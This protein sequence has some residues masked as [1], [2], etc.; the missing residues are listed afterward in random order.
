MMNVDK[1]G[2]F[3]KT[4]EAI[5]KSMNKQIDGK[6][7]IAICVYVL[8]MVGIRILAFLYPS[9]INP[10]W[11]IFGD[12]FA[13]VVIWVICLLFNIDNPSVAKVFRDIGQFLMD[14]SLEPE[15][16]LKE[17][18]IWYAALGQKYMQIFDSLGNK[19]APGVIKVGDEPTKAEI[20]KKKVED[21]KI[22]LSGGTITGEYKGLDGNGNPI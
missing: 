3:P 9:Y 17:I 19:I 12:I 16:C 20:I 21:A 18:R 8:I 4:K 7:L 15:E 11:E 22:P 13:G 1:S 5:K 14:V 2:R 6:T 10:F